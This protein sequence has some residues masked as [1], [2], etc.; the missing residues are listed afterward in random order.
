VSSRTGLTFGFRDVSAPGDQRTST[1]RATVKTIMDRN[2]G[3]GPGFDSLR[4]WLALAVLLIHSV[5]V[6]EFDRGLPQAMWN[7][8]LRPILLAVL[9]MFFGLSGFLVA[10][11][12]MRTRSVKAFLA[13][14][15]L[16]LLPALSVEITLSALVLGPLLTVVPLWLYFTDPLFLSYF[17]NIIGLV[18]FYL[19][20]LFATT[21]VAGVVN[22]NLWTLHA[23]YLCYAFMLI[24]MMSGALFDRRT[25]TIIICAGLGLLGFGNSLF[26]LGETADMYDTPVLLMSFIMG[27]VAYQWRERIPVHVGLFAAAVVALYCAWSV[28][29]AALLGLIP[30]TYCMVYLG[31]QR[32]PRLKLLPPGDYSYGIYLY[33]FPIQQALVLLFPELKVWW[34]LFPVATLVVLAF[35]MASWHVVERPALALKRRVAGERELLPAR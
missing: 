25:T 8:P 32:L 15:L 5:A 12:A 28:R 13:L 1:D 30:L 9:P 3:I 19:P 18:Q 2:D 16:R 20:G 21:P 7:G 14:R 17:G 10:G 33:G 4:L 34:L 29:G 6:A 22:L 24:L 26:G 27:V 11:S 23:E 35:A 31:V